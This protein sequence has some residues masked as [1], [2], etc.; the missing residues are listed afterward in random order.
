VH[1]DVLHPYL[2]RRP[3]IP[4]HFEKTGGIWYDIQN[5]QMASLTRHAI[6]LAFPLENGEQRFITVALVHVLSVEIL[7]PV[8]GA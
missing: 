3:F 1:P 2:A 7:V 5:P 8:P 6:E 4:F